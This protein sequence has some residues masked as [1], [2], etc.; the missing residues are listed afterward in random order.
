[1]I[2]SPA[3]FFTR[4]GVKQGTFGDQKSGPF[5][6]LALAKKWATFFVPRLGV[7]GHIG[8]LCSIPCVTDLFN[9]IALSSWSYGKKCETSLREEIDEI[10]YYQKCLLSR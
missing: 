8:I 10:A 6:S 3:N 1:M 7:Q 2:W 4:V 5:F 9:H